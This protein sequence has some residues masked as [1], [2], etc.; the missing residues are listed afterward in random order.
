MAYTWYSINISNLTPQFNP[1]NDGKNRTEI[2]GP[3]FFGSVRRS[4]PLEPKQNR[5]KK[6]RRTGSTWKP[7]CGYPV[8]RGSGQS[9]LSVDVHG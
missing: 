1:N 4:S 6:N 3:Q 9:Q 7:N 2:R 5:R 8:N